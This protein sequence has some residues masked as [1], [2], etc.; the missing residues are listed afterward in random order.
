[1]NCKICESQ[2]TKIIYTGKLRNGAVGFHT[3]T[4]V[5]IYQC[6]NC[7]VIFHTKLTEDSFYQ[8]DLYR[9]S[10]S[11]VVSLDNFNAK[12]DENIQR[13]LHYTGTT[14][15]RNKLFMDIG[16]GGGGY[17]D[18]INGAAKNV[19]LVEP[20]NSFA[21]QLRQKGYEVF[22]Y[23]QDALQ[24]YANSIEILT[25]Y[26]VIEHVDDPLNFL[27]NV[28]KL[29]APNGRAYIGTPTDYPVLRG[30]L[31]EQFDSFLFTVQHPWVFS[32]KNLQLMAEKCGFSQAEIKFY[33]FFGLGNLLAWLQF[34]QPKGDVK[35]SFISP[36]LESLYKADMAREETAEYLVLELIK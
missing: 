7:H 21:E 23:P 19:V 14:V 8:S 28:H 3:P 15:Y 20:N 35:Y 29:L 33:Q 13:K 6:G 16:C 34:G 26:D 11:E 17:A 1:M 25:S 31:G 30:L 18:F 9:E 27:Q 32:R 36:Q 24:K 4:D 12:H 22:P 2:S 10:M 5:D